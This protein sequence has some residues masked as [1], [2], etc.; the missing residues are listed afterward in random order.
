MLELFKNVFWDLTKLF[1]N[2]G[3][4]NLSKLII[5]ICSF[6]LGLLFC[7]PILI[8]SVVVWFLDPINWTMVLADLA[9]TWWMWINL[10]TAIFW[11]PINFL[12]EIWLL[13]LSIIGL[14]TWLKYSMITMFKLNLWY[15]NWENI[16]YTHNVYFDF[17]KIYKYF[18]LNVISFFILLIPVV[19]FVLSC[20]VLFVIFWWGK[21]FLNSIVTWNASILF[22]VLTIILWVILILLFVY[23]AYRVSFSYFIMLEKEFENKSALFFIKKSFEI[24]KWLVFFKFLIFLLIYI[25]FVLFLDTIDKIVYEFWYFYFIYVV[26]SFVCLFWL[27]EMYFTSIYKNMFYDK[28][29]ISDE[30]IEEIEEENVEEE[31]VENNEEIKEDKKIND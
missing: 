16:Y 11:H 14:F 7:I 22:S 10:Q 25:V 4:W 9:S 19:L 8:L 12:F 30:K 3:H 24:T 26:F 13:F 29:N 6:L 17:K 2:F 21:D 23:L 27:W 15:I 28:L 20:W 31:T 18:L 5:V 1:K